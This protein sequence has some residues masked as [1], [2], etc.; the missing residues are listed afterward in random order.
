MKATDFNFD[1]VKFKPLNTKQEEK[2]NKNIENFLKELE[3][4][5][6]LYCEKMQSIKKKSFELSLT[7]IIG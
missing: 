5:W 4:D 7:R 6:P 2:W 1:G 3:K